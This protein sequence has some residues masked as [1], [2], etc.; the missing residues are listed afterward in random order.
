MID[1]PTL[2][3]LRIISSSKTGLL[4]TGR[5]YLRH[6]VA[7]TGQQ[8]RDLHY[9]E[10]GYLIPPDDFALFS[11]VLHIFTA[12]TVLRINMVHFNNDTMRSLCVGGTQSAI[13]VPA[14]KELEIFWST[15][16]GDDYAPCFFDEGELLRMVRS[17]TSHIVNKGQNALG[18]SLLTP[19]LRLLTFKYD[20]ELRPSTLMELGALKPCGFHMV[21]EEH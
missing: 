13:L 9:D 1:A 11:P 4:D 21:Q 15:A 10:M 7:Q 12:I 6:F 2:H 18:N 3:T 5:D 20:P 17:R 8:I 19:P 16:Y 14:L